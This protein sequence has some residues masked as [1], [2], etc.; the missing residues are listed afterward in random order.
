MMFG[1][2][3]IENKN[4]YLLSVYKNGVLYC[5]SY[6]RDSISGS[7]TITSINTGEVFYSLKEFTQ[8]ILGF[9]STL[10]WYECC[11]FNEDRGTWLQLNFLVDEER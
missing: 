11:F 2:K 10:E 7:E 5:S 6:N 8:S 1:R 3:T 4:Y 9:N